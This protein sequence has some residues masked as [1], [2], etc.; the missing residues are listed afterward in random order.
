MLLLSAAIWLLAGCRSFEPGLVVASPGDPGF[1]RLTFEGKTIDWRIEDELLTIS[2][3]IRDRGWTALVLGGG[4]GLA[5]GDV[6]LVRSGL[7]GP[8]A[9]DAYV[10]EGF[11]AVP[12]TR[13]GG[14]NQLRLLSVDGGRAVVS[15]PIVGDEWDRPIERGE[16]VRLVLAEGLLGLESFAVLSMIQ[17]EIE[18]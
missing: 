12:D 9:I 7:S 18:F 5:G 11:S 6:I 14:E 1:R 4:I 16:V 13:L 2:F 17:T 10:E 3:P 15:K 8:E